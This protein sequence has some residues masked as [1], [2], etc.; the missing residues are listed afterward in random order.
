MQSN[1]IEAIGQSPLNRSV[2]RGAEI[3]RAFKPGSDLLGNG[4]LSERTGLS[5]STVSRLTQTLVVAGLLQLDREE[6]AYRLAPLVLS[7]AHAMRSGSLV[8]AVAAPHMRALAEKERVNVGLACAD[9]EEMVYLESIRYNRRVAL[10]N[11]VSGQ[12]VP[13]ELTSLGRA[14]L[15]TATTRHRQALEKTFKQRNGSHWPALKL[16]IDEAIDSVEKHG[17]CVA[18]WQPEVVAV[19]TPVMSPDGVFALN[20]SVSTQD[21]AK[22]VTRQLAPKLLALKKTIT[23]DIA[24]LHA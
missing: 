6:R 21:D 10:R 8:L 16:A 18:S 7:L 11:V 22:Q 5:P 20:I 4:E 14:Y 24:R 3:L 15:A 23:R 2:L 9:R 12:R 17:Y 1:D 19:S 13:M